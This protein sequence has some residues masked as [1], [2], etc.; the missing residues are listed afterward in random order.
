MKIIVSGLINVETTLKIN[1]FPINYYPIDYPF[2]GIK[3]EIAGVAYNVAKAFKTLG[4]EVE[5]IS[6]IGNDEEGERVKRRLKSDEIGKNYI[7]Q[8][9]LGTPASIILYDT[10]GKRQIYCDLKD[11]QDKVLE[12]S[13]IEQQIKDC[14]IVVA[15]NINFNRPLLKSARRM[16]KII[17][18]D[19]HV[20]GDIEDEYNKE[21]M[22][23]ADILFLSNEQLPCKA[24]NFL[25][26]LKDRYSHKIIVIGLGEKGALLYEREKNKIY[27]LEA[28]RIGSVINTVGAGDALFT[29]FLNYYGKGYGA[30]E[31]LKRAEIF[32]ALKI[33]SSGAS[34]GF[35]DEETV[36][37]YYVQHEITVNEIR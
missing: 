16:G 28:A 2:F 21:F 17:A 3:S 32:A 27:T 7:Y 19:V 20:L 24:E 23:Y 35:S 18:S 12:S 13:K 10:N 25:I 29:C 37:K 31:A 6:F 9:L 15:C 30:V 5:L 34:V 8:D 1:S 33:A 22:H 14:D 36:E 11:I 26:G 4:N